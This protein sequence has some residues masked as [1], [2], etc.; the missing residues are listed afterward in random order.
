M[1]RKTE[2]D[3]DVLMKMDG[4]CL[5]SPSYRN[6]LDNIRK[7]CSVESESTG[8]GGVVESVIRNKYGVPVCIKVRYGED[9]SVDYISA[10]RVSFWEPYGSF[11]PDDEYSRDMD[12]EVQALLDDGYW[13]DKEKGVYINDEGDEVV[14]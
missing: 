11:I 5:P 8:Q 2:A 9:D 10:D 14:W 12:D 6:M 1:R 7:G 13:W 3:Y 4:F